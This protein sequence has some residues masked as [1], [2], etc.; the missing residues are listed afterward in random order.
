METYDPP[1]REFTDK[2]A[3]EFRAA[4]RDPELLRK[5]HEKVAK[6]SAR[7]TPFLI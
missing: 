5:L 7:I 1:L 6:E 3:I 2:D 4:L